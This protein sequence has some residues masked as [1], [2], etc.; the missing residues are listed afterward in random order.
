LINIS[1]R[2]LLINCEGIPLEG[3]IKSVKMV[4]KMVR[5]LDRNMS[6]SILLWRLLHDLSGNLRAGQD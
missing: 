4:E 2:D 6:S 3:T 1:R 5:L